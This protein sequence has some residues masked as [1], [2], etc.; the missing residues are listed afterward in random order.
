MEKLKTIEFINGDALYINKEID[1][2]RNEE[3]EVEFYEID[4]RGEIPM[5]LLSE[6][7]VKWI[8]E[9]G[10]V[11][12]DDVSEY[13]EVKPI[14]TP[15]LVARPKKSKSVD[16]D[17]EYTGRSKKIETKLVTVISFNGDK[18]KVK[19]GKGNV[20]TVAKSTLKTL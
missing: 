5:K 10:R 18:A 11:N 7:T 2:I 8:A 14:K 12:P 4:K 1:V 9:N 17:M 3:G 16:E 13:M 6:L 15:T 20:A 19:D